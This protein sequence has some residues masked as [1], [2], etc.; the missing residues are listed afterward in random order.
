MALHFSIGFWKATATP[1]KGL[2]ILRFEEYQAGD[3]LVWSSGNKLEA[4][5]IRRN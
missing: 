2:A 3:E 1:R 4:S 5:R